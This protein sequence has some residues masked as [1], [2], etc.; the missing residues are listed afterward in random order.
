MCVSIITKEFILQNEHDVIMECIKQKIP[1]HITAEI[2]L[3][4]RKNPE[5]LFAF[6]RNYGF[7][8]IWAEC[9]FIKTANREMLLYYVNKYKLAPEAQIALVRR[10]DIEAVLSTYEHLCSE[11][12]IVMFAEN[13]DEMIKAYVKDKVFNDDVEEYLIHRG[14][15]EDIMSY[16]SENVLWHEGQV[17]LVERGNHDEIMFYITQP[18]YGFTCG[19]AEIALIDRG[20]HEELMTYLNLHKI[21]SDAMYELK[22]RGNAEE[23]AIAKLKDDF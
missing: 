11:A 9:N 19:E 8:N 4:R 22:K 5:E 17:F 20:N 13:K 12:E 14:N 21:S 2:T 16:I 23:L 3:I 1:F 15:H 18:G 6:I 10:G 7:Q